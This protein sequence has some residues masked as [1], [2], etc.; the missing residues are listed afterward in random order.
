MSPAFGVG[1]CV[2]NTG[3]IYSQ[4]SYL[5]QWQTQTQI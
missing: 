2:Y 3:Y 4:F 5:H 1:I